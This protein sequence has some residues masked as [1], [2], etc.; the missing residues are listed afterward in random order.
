MEIEKYIALIGTVVSVS[1]LVLMLINE[2]QTVKNIRLLGKHR[3]YKFHHICIILCYSNH[4]FLH[5]NKGGEHKWGELKSFVNSKFYYGADLKEVIYG[6]TFAVD[7]NH[8]QRFK[9]VNGYS[10]NTKY[11]HVDKNNIVQL[12]DDLYDDL[13]A[14]I[15]YYDQ[16]S[17]YVELAEKYKVNL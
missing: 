15:D 3:M 1:I 6:I 17:S 14:Y 11:S 10:L 4:K 5:F 2:S 12:I 9:T 16:R 7:E 8:K 13:R